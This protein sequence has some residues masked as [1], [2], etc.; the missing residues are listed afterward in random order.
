MLMFVLPMLTAVLVLVRCLGAMQGIMNMIP[1]V[2]MLVQMSMAVRVGVAVRM[3]MDDIAM[4][5][6]MGIDVRMGVLVP[7]LVRM[8]LRFA[9]RV[10]LLAVVHVISP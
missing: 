10:T 2:H 4:P 6:F 9:V 8:A 3:R 5:V 7:M 1:A